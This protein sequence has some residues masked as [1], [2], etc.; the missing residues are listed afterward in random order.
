MIVLLC[1]CF[2]DLAAKG[3]E[4]LYPVVKGGRLALS[5]ALFKL[6]SGC[7]V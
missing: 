4:K 3:M 6:H 7:G 1:V 5:N 2:L